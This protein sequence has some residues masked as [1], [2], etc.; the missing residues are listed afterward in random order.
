ML[1]DEDDTQSMFDSDDSVSIIS[2]SSESSFSSD[3]EELENDS[4]DSQQSS[5]SSSESEDEQPK[6]TKEPTTYEEEDVSYRVIGYDVGFK[7]FAFAVIAELKN[8]RYALEQMKVYD[9]AEECGCKAKYKSLSSHRLVNMTIE[10]MMKHIQ[11]TIA[12]VGKVDKIVIE[13]QPSLNRRMDF[14]A[15]TVYTTLKVC[16]EQLHKPNNVSA[17]DYQSA[18]LKLNLDV[19]SFVSNVTPT[20]WESIDKRKKK[21]PKET[22]NKTTQKK[23]RTKKQEKQEKQENDSTTRIENLIPKAKKTQSS[24]SETDDTNGKRRRKA[25]TTEQEEN[26][27]KRQKKNKVSEENKN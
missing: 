3:D 18:K 5:S 15:N 26:K 2:V 1:D 24:S 16:C 9:I 22:E 20:E 14:V 13:K 11:N 12:T 25:T 23:P 21:Q 8:G 19:K 4:D 27:P 6:P 17:V 7:N 10:F